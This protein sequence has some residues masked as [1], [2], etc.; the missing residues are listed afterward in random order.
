MPSTEVCSFESQ[1]I[2]SSTSSPARWASIAS[3]PHAGADDDRVALDA[4]PALGHHRADPAVALEGAQLLAA[5]ER[6]RPCDSSSSWNQRPASSPKVRESATSSIAT[7]EHLVPFAV[8][9]AA[10][11]VPM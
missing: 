4:E 6:R 11:S 5:V 1:T 8:S 9:E 3:A 10:T 7:I 2:P